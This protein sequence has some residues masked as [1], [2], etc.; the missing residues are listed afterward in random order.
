MIEN[1]LFKIP[2]WSI[3]TLNFKKKKPQLEKLCKAFPERKHGIQTFST[4]RQKDRTG[5]ADA[6]NN[7]VGEELSMLSQ[8]LKK[9]IHLKDLCQYL[10]KKVIITHHTI[11]VQLVSLVYFI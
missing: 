4:N 3:P 1:T 5:F 10:I 11:T 8:K 9:D 7:I 6:F 2:V